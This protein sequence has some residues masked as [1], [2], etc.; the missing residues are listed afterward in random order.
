MRVENATRA[1]RE[2]AAEERD[3]IVQVEQ[4]EQNSEPV[5]TN[6]AIGTKVR[7]SGTK[8]VQ[9]ESTT[10]DMLSFVLAIME[11]HIS[12]QFVPPNFKMYHGST[13]PNNHLKMFRNQMVFHTTPMMSS[14]VKLSPCL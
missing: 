11:V 8:T 9:E 1:V 14:S 4:T 10:V 6:Q 13:D 7:E 12:E 5:G 2:K 3:K